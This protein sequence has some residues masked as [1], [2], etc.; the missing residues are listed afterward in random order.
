MEIWAKG[1]LPFWLV[2]RPET[3]PCL[4]RPSVSSSGKWKGGA[5]SI[6]LWLVKSERESTGVLHSHLSRVQNSTKTISLQGGGAGCYLALHVLEGNLRT[7]RQG[8]EP[9]GTRSF[10]ARPSLTVCLLT[11]FP[12]LFL[13]QDDERKCVYVH[14][15]PW[16]LYRK[17]LSCW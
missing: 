8:L 3:N 9:L 2:M 14:I 5:H 17:T 15:D 10:R 16:L 4:L 7:V 11:A 6:P 1:S 13:S 12:C